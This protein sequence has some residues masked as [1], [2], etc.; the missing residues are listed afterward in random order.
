MNAGHVLREEQDTGKS[1]MPLTTLIVTPTAMGVAGG[2]DAGAQDMRKRP[3]V[4][5]L[6]LV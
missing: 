3:L 4:L 2:G 1:P 5:K 6:A